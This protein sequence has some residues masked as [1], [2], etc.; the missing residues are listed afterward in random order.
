[1]ALSILLSSLNN[2]NWL[3][4]QLRRFNF[5]VEPYS[6][7]DTFCN[8]P[9]SCYWNYADWALVVSEEAT[10]SRR[11]GSLPAAT[12]PRYNIYWGDLFRKFSGFI[13]IVERKKSFVYC[14]NNLIMK[15]GMNFFENRKRDV[16]GQL[17]RS[18]GDVSV[19]TN[20]YARKLLWGHAE[21]QWRLYE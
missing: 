19:S 18:I 20:F 15:S 9:Y 10:I 1:M 2:F 4:K 21:I 17:N 12:C 11:T 6:A 8:D 5:H 13:I 16:D 3:W 7:T 14:T